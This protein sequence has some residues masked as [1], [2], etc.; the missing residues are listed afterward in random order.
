MVPVPQRG[1][2]TE[3]GIAEIAEMLRAVPWVSE[4]DVRDEPDFPAMA[5]AV[6]ERVV[7]PL[8]AQLAR[9]ADYLCHYEGGPDRCRDEHNRRDARLARLVEALKGKHA[10]N[11]FEQWSGVVI[12][13]VCGTDAALADAGA[14]KGGTR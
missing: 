6:A 9:A 5:R 8:E 3:R 1:A 4:R 12:R 2:M 11:C 7:G 14:G 10:K 13:C